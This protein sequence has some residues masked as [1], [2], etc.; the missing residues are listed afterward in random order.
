M[1]N[2]PTITEYLI[3]TCSL[4]IDEFNE[5]YAHMP[6]EELQTIANTKFNEMDLV[7]RIGYP[8]RTLVHYTTGEST[9]GKSSAKLNHD[10]V[11]SQKDYI[12]EVKYLKNWGSSAG[13]TTASKSWEE[14]QR[15]FDWLFSEIDK[16]NKN[17]RA[18][19]IGWFNCM[20]S[21]SRCIQ[22]G[23]GPRS[24]PKPL[25]NEERLAYFPF[26]KR[27]RVPT[28]TTDLQN[29]YQAAYDEQRV[30]LVGRHGT[31]YKCLFIGSKEDKFHFAIYF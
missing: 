12:I 1:S 28:Y 5:M 17:K 14:Y 21:I 16:G 13:N 30:N 31:D 4:I 19:I 3:A 10:L 25:V 11:I 6:D 18:F 9:S 27:M 20:D 26:L 23:Q 29:D 7:V 15:D 22:L 24:G 8:F 2:M